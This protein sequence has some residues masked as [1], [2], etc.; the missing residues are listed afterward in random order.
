MDDAKQAWREVA[1]QISGLGLKLK[2]HF[3]QSAQPETEESV[4]KAFDEV[5]EALDR[6][7]ATVGNAVKD[8][9]VK[10]DVADVARS[11]GDALTTTFAQV[12][13]SLR[14]HLTSKDRPGS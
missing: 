1:D 14:T 11:L 9:S 7:F 8:P 12:S 10:Q 13:E 2:L 3:E 4:T 5:R 6:A